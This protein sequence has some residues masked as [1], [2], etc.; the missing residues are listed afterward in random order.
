MIYEARY[1]NGQRT[2]VHEFDEIVD[3]VRDTK[4]G[5]DVTVWQNGSPIMNF[6]VKHPKN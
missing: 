4:V 1:Q 3:F 6:E 5:A 2:V